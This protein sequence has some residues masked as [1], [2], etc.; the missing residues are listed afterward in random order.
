[1]RIFFVF[2]LLAVLSAG[3]QLAD[4]L[5][6]VAHNHY[7][8]RYELMTGARKQPDH[9]NAYFGLTQNELAKTDEYTSR[10]YRDAV[11]DANRMGDGYG[12]LTF[13]CFAV[14]G[15]LFLS[16]LIGLRTQRQKPV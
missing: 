12:R 14:T 4:S 8:A 7:A 6:F 3:F 2:C 9:L 10:A 16:G 5:K 13:Q 11:S 1:M 15:L